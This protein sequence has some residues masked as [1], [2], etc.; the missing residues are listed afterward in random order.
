MCWFDEPVELLERCVGSLAGVAD[1]FVALDGRWEGFPGDLVNSSPAEAAAIA[2]AS[3]AAGVAGT[4]VHPGF[5]WSS[6]VAKRTTAIDLAPTA[7][8]WL[9]IVDA[10]EYVLDV[11]RQ[12]LDEILADTPRDVAE[13]ELT[14]FASRFPLDRMRSNVYR[15]RRLFRAAAK[16]RYELAHNGVRNA[17][18]AW[19][20]GDRGYVELADAVDATAGIS[21]GH[22]IDARPVDRQRRRADYYRAR[23]AA[24]TEDWAAA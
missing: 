19:L 21:L 23:N 14:N 7:T 4:V 18:G 22:A 12:A 6:Q 10:D 8:D 1:H 17:A 15:V 13:L 11:D 2:R 3:R 5:V 16:P 9:L 20:S 24:R